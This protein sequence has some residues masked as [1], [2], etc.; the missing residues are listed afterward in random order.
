V[1]WGGRGLLNAGEGKGTGRGGVLRGLM[2][3]GFSI[4]MGMSRR[5]EGV[6][7]EGIMF[8]IYVPES[9]KRP[10]SFET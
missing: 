8:G 5:G 3:G 7:V 4:R 1:G 10:S 2:K 6:M 9:S